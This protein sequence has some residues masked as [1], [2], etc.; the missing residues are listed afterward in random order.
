M[1]V[2]EPGPGM[3]FFTL[4][5]ARLVGPTGRVI[6]IDVQPKMLAVLASRARKAGL[7]DRIEARQPK[8][9]RL[10]LEDLQSKVDFA[11]AF[12]VVHEVPNAR[13]LFRDLG[14]ALKPGARLLVAEPVSHVSAKAF[15]ETLVAARSEGFVI[16]SQPAIRRSRAAVLVRS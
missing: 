4:E 11:L 5:L 1:S 6:A 13:A 10:G 16:E 14:Q 12:A 9:D 2:L 3:G 7:G 8:G 15:D